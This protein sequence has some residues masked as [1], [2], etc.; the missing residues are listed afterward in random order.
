MNYMEKELLNQ[1]KVKKIVSISKEKEKEKK[2]DSHHAFVSVHFINN[3]SITL[4]AQN[5]F[6][7]C[8]PRSD[9]FIARPKLAYSFEFN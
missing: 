1:P 9:P 5:I 8:D 4:T 3:C 6:V 7:I 2:K